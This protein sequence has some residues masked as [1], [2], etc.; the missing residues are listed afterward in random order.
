MN[1]QP[2]F[3]LFAC[4]PVIK[5]HTRSLIYDLQRNKFKYI[6][7]MLYDILKLCDSQ[8]VEQVM[9]MYDHEEDEGIMA[10]LEALVAEELG[11]FTDT[12][13]QFPPL[14]LDYEF[15]GVISTAII[16]Y[17]DHSSYDLFE[18]IAELE[19]L[20]CKVVQI[21][22]FGASWDRLKALAKRLKSSYIYIVDVMLPY[23][24]HMT[25][26]SLAELLIS[27][28]RISPLMIYDCPEGLAKGMEQQTN[29]V[30]SRLVATRQTFESGKVPEFINEHQFTVNTEFFTE[31]HHFNTG[32]NTKV[33]VD[34]QGQIKNHIDHQKVFGQVGQDNLPTVVNGSDFRKM[35]H[36][37]NDQIKV[38][39]DCE[40]RYMC[41]DNTEIIMEE[42]GYRKAKECAYQVYDGVWGDQPDLD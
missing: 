5:G 17:D 10:Y 3:M 24:S 4:C 33:C 11:F 42:D 8:P 32:L 6:P 23:E 19:Q 36:I 35:W 39:K 30:K 13:H 1:K 31:A 38:C 7:N 40:Y 21:R 22:Y 41:L 27:E 9:S 20:R 12:P 14:P 16:E 28:H 25:L 34:A 26:D 2:Y 37:T 18:L 15:P 29:F